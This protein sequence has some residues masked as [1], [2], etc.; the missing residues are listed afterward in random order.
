MPVHLFGQM[1]DMDPIMETAKRHNLHVIEDVAQ[2][3]TST[4]KGREAGSVGN[5]ECFSFFSSK[6]L[7]GVGDGGM[8]VTSDEALCERLVSMRNHGSCPKYYHKYVG[9][10]LRL[11]PIQAAA[12]LV[13]LPQ[14]DRWSK[15]RRDNAMYYDDKFETTTV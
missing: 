11:D 6:N 8:I 2:S 14:L 13:K 9:G 10:N 4:Y 15:A 12:L 1:A 5:V 7:G 3:I